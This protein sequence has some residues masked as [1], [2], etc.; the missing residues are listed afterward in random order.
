MKEVGENMLDS[1]LQRNNL[2]LFPVG[3]LCTLLSL[4]FLSYLQLTFPPRLKPHPH[5]RR[6]DA[7]KLV[8][9]NIYVSLDSHLKHGIV[10]VTRFF[11][12]TFY[13]SE[14]ESGG[15]MDLVVVTDM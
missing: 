6:T 4:S 1:S 7:Y 9:I 2:R 3:H 11:K 8:C 10:G 12:R 5:A 13:D 14:I 15:V